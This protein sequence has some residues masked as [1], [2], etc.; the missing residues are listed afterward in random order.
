MN[1]FIFGGLLGAAI[2]AL[3]AP[4]TGHETKDNL[5][6][7][8]KS[9]LGKA[10]DFKDKTRHSIDEIKQVTQDKAKHL[11]SDLKEKAESIAHRFDNITAKGASVL[12]DDEII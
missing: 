6:Q 4:K 11:V 7:A 12:I 8:Y 3:I 10:K 9:G 2:A 1:G 5:V